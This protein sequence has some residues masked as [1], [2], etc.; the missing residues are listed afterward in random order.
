VNERRAQYARALGLEPGASGGE[1][2]LHLDYG[3]LDLGLI[4]DSQLN[5]SGDYQIFGETFENVV[6]K[7]AKAY[8]VPVALITGQGN[9]G[10]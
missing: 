3:T 8:D 9:G 5:S 4:R 6:K 10:S 2:F 1:T 7:I